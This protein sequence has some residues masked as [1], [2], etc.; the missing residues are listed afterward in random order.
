MMSKLGHID[1]RHHVNK[2]YYTLTRTGCLK[3]G[4]AQKQ[5][6]TSANCTHTELIRLPLKTRVYYNPHS[7]TQ[8]RT[9]INVIAA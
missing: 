4:P 8:T 2:Y 9:C 6:H 7:D 3:T 5:T 1:V